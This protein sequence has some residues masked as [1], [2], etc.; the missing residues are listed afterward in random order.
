MHLKLSSPLSHAWEKGC[1]PMTNISALITNSAL[2]CL[3]HKTPTST[4][5]HFL[6][7]TA[8]SLGRHI[9]MDTSQAGQEVLVHVP[10]RRKWD[11]GHSSQHSFIH[12]ATWTDTFVCF[13]K[14]A[15]SSLR[16]RNCP[17]GFS[18]VTNVTD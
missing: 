11:L 7:I 15:A 9:P 6:G 12:T 3:F 1:I 10:Q 13:Y 2:L 18:P 14:G 17:G 5:W 16:P 4:Y 8:A